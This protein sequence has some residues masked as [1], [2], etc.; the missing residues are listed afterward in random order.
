MDDFLSQASL[1]HYRTLN[2]DNQRI[3][4][5]LRDL[6]QRLG[7]EIREVFLGGQGGGLCRLRDKQ[8]LFIDSAAELVDQVARTAEGLANLPDL[9]GIFLLPEVREVLERFGKK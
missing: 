8:V 4:L 5:E 7:I 1:R 2:V 6:A 9:Q 3:L